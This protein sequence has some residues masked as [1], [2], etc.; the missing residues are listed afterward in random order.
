M[1]KP[2]T[3]NDT[4][5]LKPLDQ[6]DIGT[7]KG[8]GPKTKERL[9]R[10]GIHNLQDLLFHLPARYEDRTF[11]TPISQLRPQSLALFEGEIIAS[12]IVLGG[13]RSLA[14]KLRDNGAVI[15]LRFFHFSMAQK[16][17]LKVGFRLRCY[18]EIRFGRQSIE[19]I[20]PEYTVIPDGKDIPLDNSLT[21]VYP[22]TE[23]LHQGSFRKLIAQAVPKV[24]DHVVTELLPSAMVQ[25][26][27]A[28]LLKE[29]A[30]LLVAGKAAPEV[31]L[32]LSNTLSMLHAPVHLEIKRLQL[33]QQRLAFEELLAHH[34]SLL[35]MRQQL[36]QIKAPALVRDAKKE[37]QFKN[38]L[39][40]QLTSAQQRVSDEIDANIASTLPMLRLVQGDV[41][42]GKTVVGALA[43]LQ[44]I[45]SGFQTAMMAPT[46]I[47]TEQHAKAFTQWFEPLGISCA[48]LSGQQTTKQRNAELTRISSGEAQMVIGTHALI[49]EAVSYHRLGVIIIDEQHRFGVAQRLTLR[50]KAIESG[51]CPHQLI[52]TAT[53]IPRTLAMTAYADLDVSVIDE[54][55]PGRTPINTTVFDNNSRPRII[56]RVHKACQDGRQAYWVCTLVEESDVLQ[57]QA[58]EKS[59]EELQEAL[60]DLKVGLV[61]GRMK[62]QEKADVMQAFKDNQLHLLVATTVIEVGVDVPNASLMIIE[63]AERL[64]LSQIHQL[65][66]RVGRGDTESFCV[67]MYQSPLSNNGRSRL[68]TLRASTDGFYIAEQDLLLRGPGEVLG[69]RQTGMLQFR[70]ADLNRDEH[71][72]A[73]VHELASD[74]QLYPTQSEQLIQRWLG[75]AEAYGNA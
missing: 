57:C 41:G 58:A 3:P 21:P 43:A 52:M 4:A 46:E 9:Q 1:T 8:A 10:I 50:E 65:R 38:A 72:L 70:I 16:N 55:P 56:D 33:Y 71:L 67:L 54:L 15:S 59:A 2:K 26:L 60:P 40:F 20:H 27:T 49:Q 29:N 45:S 5:S 62:A 44:A 61:H 37:Q 14:C 74:M 11:L 73:V 7:L 53:P 30:D 68:D 28:L 36:Q 75:H 66:G 22:S 63:N 31:N 13:R 19:C 35:K 64:G 25:R 6:I 47:L 24:Q 48:M 69:T 18:G 32:S 23:G 34:L 17:S 51:V 12:G 42:C 39:G